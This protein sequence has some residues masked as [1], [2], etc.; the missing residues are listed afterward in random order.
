[1]RRR[2]GR[3][4]LDTSRAQYDQA[5]LDYQHEIGRRHHRT[6]KNLTDGATSTAIVPFRDLFA[7]VFPVTFTLRPFLA[8]V[9]ARRR[10]LA[11]VRWASEGRWRGFRRNAMSR[12]E[13]SRANRCLSLTPTAAAPWLFVGLL[14]ACR[15]EDEPADEERSGSPPSDAEPEGELVYERWTTRS[16]G[17]EIVHIEEQGEWTI[18][19]AERAARP[20]EYVGEGE[21]YSEEFWHD[22][23]ADGTILHG[24]RITRAEIEPVVPIVTRKRPG[25]A[26][27]LAERIAIAPAHARFDVMLHVDGP[28]ERPLPWLPPPSLATAEEIASAR[29][30]RHA[31][32]AEQQEL[33]D[34]AA[35]GVAQDIA[36]RG[37]KVSGMLA[38]VGWV[39]A[40][41]DGVGIQALAQREDVLA[42]VEESVG[43]D[44][45]LGD[46]VP[47]GEL[48]TVTG[49]EAYQNAGYDGRLGNLGTE[50]LLGII[51]SY[52][53]ED[54]ACFLGNASCAP[55]DRLRDRFECGTTSC[56][57]P[58]TNFSHSSEGSHGTVVASIA[59]GDYNDHQADAHEAS[60]AFGLGSTWEDD[61]T[62]FA[63]EANLYYYAAF[64]DARRVHAYECAREWEDAPSDCAQVDV[65]NV[66][67]GSDPAGNEC[68]AYSWLPVENALED[69]VDDGLLVAAITHNDND[70]PGNDECRVRSPADMPKAL[71]VGAPV[72][73]EGDA[74]STWSY[75]P[76]SNRGGGMVR[77]GFIQYST[78]MTM[79][80]LVASGRPGF[81]TDRDGD[82]GEVD[83]DGPLFGSPLAAYDEGT[84]YAA[85][86]VSGAAVLVEHRWLDFSY[87]WIDSPG[88]LHAV[89][90]TMGDR[91]TIG[92][93]GAT[94]DA[95]IHSNRIRCGADHYFGLGRLRLRA[96]NSMYY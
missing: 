75:A 14:F 16:P 31:A 85:P 72:P 12:T 22:E 61:A 15:A 30:A 92:S 60:I 88:R 82:Y 63:T 45:V 29:E 89:M 47:L 68:D 40:T 90:L 6:A 74:Y 44:G 28:P 70:Y 4:I 69:A 83:V 73:D 26:P 56:G 46:P 8:W 1:M 3:W 66:S 53:F 5:W 2:F 10:I 43:G 87:G 91:A 38:S 20:W 34:A 32:A 51:E 86:Q 67:H 7:L 57:S 27:R 96:H 65:V 19:L 36:E 59:V 33:F 35:S 42:I 54:D 24:Y 64:N 62:G 49:V 58:V 71:A 50:L 78:A 21:L 76:Y 80:D 48:R 77:N 81:V 9:G 55:N 25:L 17:G 23:L 37:G 93:S 39:A 13:L 94:E 84:S 11:C 79:V 18:A 41:L 52:P 95:C